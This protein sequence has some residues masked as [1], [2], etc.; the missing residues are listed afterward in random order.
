MVTHTHPHRA[1]VTGVQ[2]LAGLLVAA[3]LVV[4]GAGFAQPISPPPTD[5][6]LLNPTFA[7]P[8]PL[9]RVKPAPHLIVLEP[10]T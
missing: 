3:P 7:V 10:L 9:A 8:E 4:W 2:V 1:A 5:R 6:V